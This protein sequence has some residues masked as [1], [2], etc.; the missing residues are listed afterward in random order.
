MFSGVYGALIQRKIKKFIAYSSVSTV[1]YILASLSGDNILM[2]QQCLFYITVYVLT[3]VPIFLLV[4]NYRLSNQLCIDYIR[5]FS[6]TY[7]QNNVIFFLLFTFFLSLAGVPPFS[8]FVSK[9][10]LFTGLGSDGL[11]F[12]LLCGLVIAIISC[13]YY[14]RFAKIMFYESHSTNSIQSTSFFF[15]TFTYSSSVV[16]CGFFVF[17]FIFLFYSS[18]LEDISQ[19][20]S[21]SLYL[22]I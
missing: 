22:D 18:I 21:M 1:G 11:F 7:T 20:V 2:V 17:N 16:T 12:L 8:G 6:S 14:L 9:L 19:Y 4:L 3:L 15:S 5:S 10:S 13:Y